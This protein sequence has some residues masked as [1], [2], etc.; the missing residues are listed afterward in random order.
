MDVT[1]V[2]TIAGA[3]NTSRAL[4]PSALPVFDGD[5]VTGTDGETSLGADGVNSS[6]EFDM[7]LAALNPNRIYSGRLAALSANLSLRRRPIIVLFTGRSVVLA[8]ASKFSP[9]PKASANG[10]RHSEIIPEHRA[11]VPQRVYPDGLLAFARLI[12]HLK[13]EST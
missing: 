4:P 7:K 10:S 5:G 12:S 8:S 3:F 6:E 13:T 2:A 9:F 11:I 1:E